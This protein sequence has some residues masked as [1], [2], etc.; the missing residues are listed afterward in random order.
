ME[1]MYDSLSCNF[2]E[3]LSHILLMNEVS[4]LFISR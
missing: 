4:L 2:I 1:I 3:I